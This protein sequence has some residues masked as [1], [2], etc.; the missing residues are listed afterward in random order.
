MYLNQINEHPSL[1]YHFGAAQ[2]ACP[3]QLESL[4]VG[5]ESNDAFYS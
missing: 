3:L 1:I 5:K 2:F 4:R